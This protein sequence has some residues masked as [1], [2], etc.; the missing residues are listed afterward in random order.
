MAWLNWIGTGALLAALSVGLGAFGAHALKNSL[1]AK[2]LDVFETAVRYQMYHALA[3]VML[4][5]VM[6]K[7]DTTL[8]SISGTLFTIGILFFSGSL[9][10]LIF[11][12]Q[13]WLGMITPVGGLALILA[14]ILLAVG[15]FKAG[16]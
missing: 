13:R 6:A 12:G 15:V 16:F 3:L 2:E 10:A 4:G 8:L 5:V 7:V 9:Y 14:W 1:S 11:S